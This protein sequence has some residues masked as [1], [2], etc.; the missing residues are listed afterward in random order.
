M[1]AGRDR[2]GGRK[3]RRGV[4]GSRGRR[5]AARGPDLCLVLGGD[6]SI[7]W[8]LRR[9]AGT[10]RAGLRGQLRHGRLPR[11][12]RARAARRGAAAGLRRRVRDRST[13]PG[14]RSSAGAGRRSAFNDVTFSRRPHGRVAELSYRIAGEEVGPRALRRPR[15]RDP[16]R[17]HRLQPRQRRPDPRLGGGGLRGQLHRPA[18]AHRAG[19]GRR[20]RRRPRT[21]AT[22][23]AASRS[24]SR[25]TATRCGSWRPGAE[26]EV[27]F[28]DRVG[29]LAQLPG[30]SFYRRIREKFGHLAR[31]SEPGRRVRRR[32]LLDRAAM[33]RELRIENLLLIERAELRFGAGLQR[34]HRRDRRRQDG[35]RP[36]ARPADG[37]PGPRRRSSGRAPARP[38]SRAS[39]T[40]RRSCSARPR[41]GRARRAPARG[42]RGAGPRAAGLGRRGAPRPSSPAAPPPRPTCACSAPRLLA[43]YGQHEHRKLTLAS[44][45]LE[46]LDGF[47]GAEHLEQRR[48]YREAHREHAQAARRELAELRERD[49][50]RERDLD[51]LRFELCRDRGR[52]RPTPARRHELA[53][54]RERLAPRREPARSPP[55]RAPHAAA[56][57]RGRGTAA[58]TAALSAA[59]GAL[60]GAAG[61]RRRPR[62]ARGAGRRPRARAG[63]RRQRSCAPTPSGS[64]PTRGGWRRSRSASSRSTA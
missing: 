35:A 7:L 5:R 43:F 33:L 22:R 21:S 4:G 18:H 53:A 17:L 51:L 41:A 12:R 49:G 2:R 44:A 54:E 11:R 30:S 28:R 40:C 39:S 46:V 50:A 20:S 48:R 60:A 10:E 37:R 3:A 47:A 25:S 36:L 24:R 61:R 45:Q 42:R 23:P 19:A 38:G 62:R 6:G 29:R 63:R 55:R 32:P 8:A 9:Y 26:A 27:R 31:L 13:C 56:A 64:R 15:R 16:D 58:A 59:E 1:A 52:R 34:D 14:S 57:E